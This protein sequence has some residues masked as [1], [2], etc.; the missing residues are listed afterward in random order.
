M[1]TTSNQ[2]ILTRGGWTKLNIN[3]VNPDGSVVHIY[4]IEGNLTGQKIESARNA[5]VA[6]ELENG[7]EL[8]EGS[9]FLEKWELEKDPYLVDNGTQLY[10]TNPHRIAKLF[11]QAANQNLSLS[12]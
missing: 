12:K 2:A 8:L 3:V 9:S 10:L 1:Q 6:A 7:L 5:I 4:Q 11:K